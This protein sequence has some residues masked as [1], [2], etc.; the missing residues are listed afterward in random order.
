MRNL[1][2]WLWKGW[3]AHGTKV[4]GTASSS[5]AGIIAIPELLP[6]AHVKWWALA[7]VLTGAAG[8]A[9]GF[10]NSRANGPQP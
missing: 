6:H 9:R 4:L 3:G 10:Q 8:I 7:G 5:I 1:F 2:R